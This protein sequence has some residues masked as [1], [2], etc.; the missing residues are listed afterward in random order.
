MHP[1]PVHFGVDAVTLVERPWA[2]SVNQ[3]VQQILPCFP[4]E[5]SRARFTCFTRASEYSVPAALR[6]M[7]V[8]WVQPPGRNFTWRHLTLPRA[9]RKAGIDVMWFPFSVVPLIIGCRSVVT[10]HDLSFIALPHLFG[11]RTRSYLSFMLRRTL[12]QAAHITTISQFTADELIRC[13]GVDSRRMSVVHHGSDTRASSSPA[14]DA[15]QVLSRLGLS[16]PYFLFLDGISPRKNLRLLLRL[17]VRPSTAMATSQFVITGN[18]ASLRRSLEELDLG[19][20]IGRRI[21]LPGIV[22][23]GD[24]DVLY[25]NARALLYLSKYEGFG[26]P[27][28]EAFARDCPVIGLAASSIPEVAGDAALYVEPGNIS[29][30]A[31]AL[32]DALNDQTR[33]QLINRGRKRALKFSWARTAQ[34]LYDVLSD[35]AAA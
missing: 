15:G 13:F 34:Q 28:V 22:P 5:I 24:L 8:E 20:Q 27:I 3:V 1:Q 25:R 14:S 30:L 12:A 17:L 11:W 26:L 10:V 19:G 6:Q 33:N 4:I 35:T 16:E 31:S 21:I 7:P 32:G 29:Q 18:I 23:P 2:N 9:I